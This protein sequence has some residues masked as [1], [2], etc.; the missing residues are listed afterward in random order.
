MRFSLRSGDRRACASSISRWGSGSSA[1]R[2]GRAAPAAGSST[3]FRM[4]RN[5]GAY[6]SSSPSSSRSTAPKLW[7]KL[8]RRGGR[9]AFPV[10]DANCRSRGCSPTTPRRT[11]AA[12]PERHP[13]RPT[14]AT[15]Y[16]Q[17]ASISN[18][19]C[20]PPP[21]C[22]T[23]SRPSWAASRTAASASVQTIPNRAHPAGPTTDSDHRRK[24]CPLLQTESSNSLH[25][26]LQTPTRVT[27]FV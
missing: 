26:C 17:P 6:C 8:T 4:S 7:L 10:R 9:P 15:A 19:C 24:K 16:A 5:C 22:A 27:E 12:Q 13:C 18:G 14:S 25:Q 20:T 2:S 3:W 1:G 23:P 21:H 11:S